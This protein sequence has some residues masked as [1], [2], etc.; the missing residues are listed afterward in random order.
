MHFY[1]I[2]FNNVII[3]KKTEKISLRIT[4][5]LK[6]EISKYAKLRGI[7]TGQLIRD[8]IEVFTSNQVHNSPTHYYRHIDGRQFSNMK[9][10]CEEL[11]LSSHA[12]R[13]LVKLNV[14]EKINFEQHQAKEHGNEIQ[15]TTRRRGI[16][17]NRI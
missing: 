7:S 5:K 1:T 8:W 13:K 15:T 6:S 16:E 17:T 3:M 2:K 9:I 10:A 14:I 4:E 11:K 12:F